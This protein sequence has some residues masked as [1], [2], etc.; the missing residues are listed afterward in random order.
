MN[1]KF[2]SPQYQEVTDRADAIHMF[3]ID[4]FDLSTMVPVPKS[5][6]GLERVNF[7]RQHLQTFHR[8]RIKLNSCCQRGTDGKASSTREIISVTPI[9]WQLFIW[10]LFILLFVCL[11]YSRFPVSPMFAFVSPSLYGHEASIQRGCK[12]GEEGRYGWTA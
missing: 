8:A 10:Q 12:N 3:T 2:T 1:V 7:F 11:Q 4:E 6:G 9:I 5:V